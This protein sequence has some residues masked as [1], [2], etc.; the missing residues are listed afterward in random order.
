MQ[1]PYYNPPCY[2]GGASGSSATYDMR[3]LAAAIKYHAD[4]M[5]YVNERYKKALHTEVVPKDH[6]FEVPE[7][8]YPVSFGGNEHE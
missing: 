5:L 1:K 3:E 7:K 2:G 4:V 8:V 6:K